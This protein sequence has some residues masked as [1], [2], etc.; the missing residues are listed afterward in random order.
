MIMNVNIQKAKRVDPS[1]YVRYTSKPSKDKL[2]K[3]IVYGLDSSVNTLNIPGFKQSSGT[4]RFNTNS[5]TWKPNTTQSYIK[6][7]QIF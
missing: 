6:N 4:S 7:H 1:K 3:Q 2:T 5:L